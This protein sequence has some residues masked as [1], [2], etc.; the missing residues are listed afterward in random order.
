MAQGKELLAG[1]LELFRE[2][3]V[4]LSD[5]ARRAAETVSGG[6]CSVIF[7]GMDR[8]AA[9]LIALSDTLRENAVATIRKPGCRSGSALLT[10]TM[11]MPPRVSPD[12]WGLTWFARNARWR[13]N[14]T[15]LTRAR[16]SGTVCMVGDG[17]NDALA[18]KTSHAEL[19]WRHRK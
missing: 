19:P 16:K 9:G 6:G 11:G 2:N 13:T 18:L 15:G 1:N 17:I 3:G 14:S 8:Q 12:N 10:G 4:E 7:I 5:E